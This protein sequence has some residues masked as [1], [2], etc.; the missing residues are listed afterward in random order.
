MDV[1]SAQG[2]GH[3]AAGRG[4]WSLRFLGVGGSHCD[5]LGTAAA[6]L[7]RDGRPTLLIDCGHGTPQRHRS[8][9][10]AAPRAMFLT[11]VHLDHVGGLEQL[12]SRVALAAEQCPPPRL[13]VP[14]SILPALHRRIGDLRCSLAEGGCNFWDAFQVVPVGDGFWHEGLWFDVFE[15]RHHAPAFAYGLRL[16]GRFL[17]T[18]DTRP[19]PE[20]L[21][22]LGSTGER[23]FHDCALEG[24]PSH[25]GWADIER[26]YEAGLRERLVL[27]HYESA[28][29]G[30]RLRELGAVVAR[31]GEAFVLD[32]WRTHGD[33]PGA[34]PGL[35][36]AG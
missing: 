2:L 29:A 35:R 9:Y 28:Q 3:F 23:L 16:A 18:G 4:T 24:N 30:R 17:Y 22:T 5:G 25:T 13:F 10:G 1:N 36:L 20:V 15:A 26:E 12:Y 19:I 6:V 34:G 7:E 21:R 14:V 8:R 33:A 11:H 31:P 32:G 27:Y